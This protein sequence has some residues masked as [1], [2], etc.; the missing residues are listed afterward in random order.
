MD[1]KL[2]MKTNYLVVGPCTF[3]IGK[4]INEAAQNC[5]KAGCRKTANATL[6]QYIH[7]TKDPEVIWIDVLNVQMK[8]GTTSIKL[9][10]KIKLG[11]LLT[12]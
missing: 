6:I 3:G 12:K 9:F 8:T 2:N 1:E 11:A 5:L 7:P 4:T 10:D